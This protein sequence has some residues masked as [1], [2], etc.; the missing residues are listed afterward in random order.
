ML[1]GWK[2]NDHELGAGRCGIVIHFNTLSTSIWYIKE[3]TDPAYLS[4][5]AF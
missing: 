2:G 3:A 1:R 4:L 5:I